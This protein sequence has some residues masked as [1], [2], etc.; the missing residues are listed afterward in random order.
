MELKYALLLIIG[1]FMAR[2]AFTDIKT[3]EISNIE[4]LVFLP[5]VLFYN[6]YFHITDYS[7]WFVVVVLIVSIT[8]WVASFYITNGTGFGGGDAKLMMILVFLF[9]YT[10]YWYFTLLTF[11]FGLM[12]YL[13][14]VINKKIVNKNDLPL[15]VAMALSYLV[16]VW[17][18]I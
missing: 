1:C 6:F 17:A 14:S 12:Y 16:F 4:L 5:I 13:P 18:L 15:A 10:T 11:V 7:N 8:L 9:P 2:F 3:R